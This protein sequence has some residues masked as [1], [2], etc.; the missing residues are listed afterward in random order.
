MGIVRAMGKAARRE[1]KKGITHTVKR[2]V[3]QARSRKSQAT[4]ARTK[5]QDTRRK[6]N[7]PR[8]KQQGGLFW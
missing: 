8:M 4:K 3:R 2:V 7:L 1:I 6:K 5:A